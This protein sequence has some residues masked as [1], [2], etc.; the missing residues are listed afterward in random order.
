MESHSA[1][2]LQDDEKPKENRKTML[3]LTQSSQKNTETRKGPAVVLGHRT[4][5][6][7]NEQGNTQ[8]LMIY[9]K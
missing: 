9:P 2:L 7:P 3:N 5:Q 8:R 1:H 4:V 6:K